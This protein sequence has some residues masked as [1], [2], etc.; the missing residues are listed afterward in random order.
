M[1]PSLSGGKAR[2]NPF[3]KS[4]DKRIISWIK[5]LAQI[6]TGKMLIEKFIL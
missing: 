4:I 5:H 2:N 6:N 1:F 3:E